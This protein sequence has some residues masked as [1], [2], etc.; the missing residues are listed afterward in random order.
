MANTPFLSALTQAGLAKETTWGTA[1]APTTADQFFP[2]VNPKSEDVIESIYDQGYR[3]RIS[4]QQGYQQGYRQS[5]YS[6]ESQWY[7]DVCGNWLMGIFGTDG[8]ASGSTHP[9]TVLNT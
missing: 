3:G 6:F 8:W 4:K 5:K 9:F 1:V 7:P 2:V